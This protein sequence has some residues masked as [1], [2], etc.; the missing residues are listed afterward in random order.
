MCCHLIF[1]VNPLR[2]TEEC[3]HSIEK[4]ILCKVTIGVGKVPKWQNVA[5]DEHCLGCTPVSQMMDSVEQVN[6]LV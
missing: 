1:V 2:F 5:V 6:A 3:W 4:T